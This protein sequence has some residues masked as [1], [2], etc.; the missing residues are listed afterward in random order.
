MYVL[1]FT[2][3]PTVNILYTWM[4][5]EMNIIYFNKNLVYAALLALSVNVLWTQF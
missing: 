4:E 2:A 5:N 1:K 3:E